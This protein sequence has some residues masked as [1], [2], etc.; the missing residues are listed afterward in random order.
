MLSPNSREMAAFKQSSADNG[1][2]VSLNNSYIESIYDVAAERYDQLVEI[3]PKFLGSGV[4]L[5]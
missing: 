4:S 3:G 1:Q 2:L 5:L